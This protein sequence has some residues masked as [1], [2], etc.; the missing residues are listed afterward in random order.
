MFT[1]MLN[2]T[3][4]YD[5]LLLL[6][7][8]AWGTTY[9]VAKETVHF[10]SIPTFLFLRFGIAGF[11]TLFLV[12]QEW[13][14]ATS[15]TLKKGAVLG[16]LLAASI[17]VET[18]GVT[19]TTSSNAGVLISLTILFVP[20]LESFTDSK[21]HLKRFFPAACL[22]VLGAVLLT[23]HGRFSF[24]LG[25]ALILIS[26]AT[27]AL[28][29]IIARKF[30]HTEMNSTGLLTALQFGVSAILFF[31]IAEMNS[32]LPNDLASIQWKTVGLI[33]YVVL[34]CTVFAFVVQMKV[35]KTRLASHVGL[36]LG[37]EPV[38]A[39]LIGVLIAHEQIFI[40]GWA[41]IA[42]IIVATYLGQ[43]VLRLGFEAGGRRSVAGLPI[44]ESE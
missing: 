26:A 40:Q 34:F 25:D 18:L 8:F 16:L 11:I 44:R 6:T 36:L 24:N 23:F 5:F 19:K 13:R 30:T 29:L 15:G 21:I 28:H 37:T 38:F 1:S 7:A 2:K 43:R 39:A 3:C 20:L 22:S 12:K 17:G 31:I 42:M 4:T 27:R 35:V 32:K 33:A 10:I 9:L 41:G 14:Y